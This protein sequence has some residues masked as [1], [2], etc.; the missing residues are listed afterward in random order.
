MTFLQHRAHAQAP[1]FR[2]QTIGLGGF[3]AVLA[4]SA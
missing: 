1:S 3:G 4:L 2:I